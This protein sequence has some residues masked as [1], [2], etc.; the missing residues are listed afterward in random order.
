[1][2]RLLTSGGKSTRASTSAS[3]L[4][5][6]I[7]GW[8]SWLVW[9][10]CQSP[11]LSRVFSNTIVQK[12]Q[13]FSTWSS[14][15]SNSHIHTWHP[16]ILE[17]PYLQLYGPLS[18]NNVSAFKYA[19]YVCHSLEALVLTQLCSNKKKWKWKMIVFGVLSFFLFNKSRNPYFQKKRRKHANYTA[20]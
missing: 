9:S 18:Q 6:N 2:S 17:K 15:L 16:Y 8:F 13:F 7:Q 19:V 1:M 3:V 4:P 10:P 5:M 20:A 11:G 14:L 12:H